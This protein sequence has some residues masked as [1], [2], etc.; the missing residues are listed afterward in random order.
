M[1][2]PNARDA[3]FY[4]PTTKPK[5]AH[6]EAQ[7]FAV[8]AGCSDVGGIFVL[9]RTILIASIVKDVTYPTIMV[10]LGPVVLTP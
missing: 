8:R 1:V 9:A 3:T 4:F 5:I 7:K 2:Y 6:M 10:Q